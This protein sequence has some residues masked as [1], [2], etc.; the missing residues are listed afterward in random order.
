LPPRRIGGILFPLRSAS[1]LL[2][3]LLALGSANADVTATITLTG[4]PGSPDTTFIA[5]AS[6]CGE[7]P[8]RHTE[9][10]K[11]GPKGELAEVVVWIVDPKFAANLP[12][13]PEPVMRQINCRYDPHVLAVVAGAPFK[14]VNG[15]PTLHNVL[16]R[17]YTGPTDPPGD[18]LFN[19]GQ[20]Y[21]GQVS[22]EQFDAP[23]IYTLQCNVHSW[24]QAWVR[25]FPHGCFAVT[26]VDG[27]A[28]L[29][30]SAHLLDGTYKIDAWHPR[31]AA[32][33]EQTITVKNS[34]ARATFQFQGAKSL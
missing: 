33:L 32:P 31:F 24:M 15:D 8:V 34:A 25:A 9:N 21:R 23:G 26:G 14:I 13:V 16:A 5:S 27:R 4:A 6:N 30:L 2:L 20:S 17:V 1:L 19:L 29:Q 11:I 7:S 22:E 3:S 18:T 10:W 28:T 12:A